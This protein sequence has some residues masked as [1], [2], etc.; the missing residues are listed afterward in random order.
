VGEI[1][2]LSHKRMMAPKFEIHR[3]QKSERIETNKNST[4]EYWDPSLEEP[5]KLRQNSLFIIPS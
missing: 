1:K 4:L 5:K 3:V 2:N